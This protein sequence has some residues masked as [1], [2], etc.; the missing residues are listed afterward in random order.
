MP[1]LDLLIPQRGQT[2]FGNA[3]C[4]DAQVVS[5]SAGIYVVLPSYSRELRWGPCQPADAGVA[6]GDKIA[7][8]ITESGVPYLLGATRPPASIASAIRVYGPTV[9]TTIPKEVWTLI[10][11]TGEQRTYGLVNFRLL[12]TG[13][14]AGGLEC[15]TA[16]VYDLVGA[17]SFNP[18]K[19]TGAIAVWVTELKDTQS[20]DL[21]QSGIPAGNLETPQL[22]SGEAHLD[23]GD[24]IGLQ[25]WSD[26]ETSTT[27]NPLTEWLGATWIG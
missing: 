14:Y 15:L 18:I 26:T 6:V 17:V 16:G 13:T 20:W 1:Q 3:Q 2:P 21:K 27:S 23:V 7:V 4:Y 8:V 12:T 11:L 5:V 19:K 24:I 25:A 9:A 22:V 10:P